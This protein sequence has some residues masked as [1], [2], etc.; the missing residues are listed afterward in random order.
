RWFPPPHGTLKVSC[1]GATSE[2]R[3]AGGAGM[4]VRD[5]PDTVL[6]AAA[7]KSQRTNDPP[8]IEAFAILEAM[9]LVLV[10]GWR[11]IVFESDAEVVLDE[12]KATKFNSLWLRD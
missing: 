9:E 11:N 6:M 10:K 3:R 4:A 1:D 12:I 2:G 7:T 5:G 8:T